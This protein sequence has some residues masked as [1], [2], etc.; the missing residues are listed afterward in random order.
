MNMND[1]EINP[2][3]N[4]DNILQMTCGITLAD[5][6]S[7]DPNERD[8]ELTAFLSATCTTFPQMQMHEM[9]D[10]Y[11]FRAREI[12]KEISKQRIAIWNPLSLLMNPTI[13]EIND[14]T[15]VVEQLKVL[16]GTDPSHCR[17]LVQWVK[18]RAEKTSRE[19]LF[20]SDATCRDFF[21]KCL[22]HMKN[23]IHIMIEVGAN[24]MIFS[25]DK[26]CPLFVQFSHQSLLSYLTGEEFA[27]GFATKSFCASRIRQHAPYREGRIFSVL[28]ES[29]DEEELDKSISKLFHLQRYVDGHGYR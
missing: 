4:V 24:F 3:Q 22:F 27:R 10:V 14:A 9:K 13:D 19:T 11:H 2:A 15:L 21:Y 29:L 16:S 6:L 25:L 26:I 7:K 17:I 20:A 28:Y 1:E 18:D 12:K 5:E 8:E 23:F